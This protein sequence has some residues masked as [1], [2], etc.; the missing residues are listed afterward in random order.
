MTLMSNTALRVQGLKS[1]I[2][3]SATL[4]CLIASGCSSEKEFDPK[5]LSQGDTPEIS[6]ANNAMEDFMKNQGKAATKKSD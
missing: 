6:Q 1:S 4:F 2:L 3:L 5:A